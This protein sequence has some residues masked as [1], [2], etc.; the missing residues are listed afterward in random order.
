MRFR[1]EFFTLSAFMSLVAIGC[2]LRA[3]P[4]ASGVRN[5][6]NN[7]WQFVLNAPADNVRVLRDGGNAVELGALAAGRHT[8]NMTNFNSF[9][10]VVTD[11]A[12]VGWTRI[13]D[14][15]N[16]FTNFEQPTGLAISTDP[17]SPFFG[18]IYVNNSRTNATVTGRPMGAGIY[19][20]TA[21][22]LGVAWPT[23]S[24]R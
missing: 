14:P 17:S 22:L 4:Y 3:A 20:L 13:S 16:R 2:T 15:A 7:V 21:D 8:F 5:T 24:P 1:C 19:A 23:T 12:P 18:T 10:I 9:D 6:G 11:S